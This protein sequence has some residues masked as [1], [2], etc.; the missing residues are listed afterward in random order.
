M[1]RCYPVGM[2]CLLLAAVLLVS[3][4]VRAQ[5]SPPGLGEAETA[6]WMAAGVRQQLDA[7]DRRES[8]TYV[9]LGAVSEHL[10]VPNEPAILVVNEEIS[11]K[12]AERWTY[13][14]ALSYRRQNEYAPTEPVE[15][16]QE[17]RFYGRFSNV[18]K[19]GR[20]KLTSTFRPELRTFYTT[21]FAPAAEPLQLRFRVREQLAVQ[22]DANA[23]HRLIGSAEVLSSIAT[24]GDCAYRE[25]RFY[26][27]Y[28]LDRERWPVV[29]NVGYMNDLIGRG[30]AIADVH[31]L[32]FDV[33]WVNP[34]GKTHT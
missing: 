33:T 6:T 13:S 16:R 15:R 17:L 10:G 3:S 28:S 34:F 4:S 24:L 7:A 5:I 26:L 18:L 19:T 27:C 11:D 21:S 8:M 2:R 25:S 30:S 20:L 22:L 9:G 14:F 1:D 12:F 29:L 23:V 32:A 31:Y